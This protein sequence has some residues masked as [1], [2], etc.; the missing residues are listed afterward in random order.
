MRLSVAAF[1]TEDEIERLASTVELLAAH[2]PE[3]RPAA[4]DADPDRG[5]GM[6]VDRPPVRPRGPPSPALE[7]RWRQ[8]RN[9][10]RPVVR[11]VMASLVIA[12][13]LAV[14][15]LVYDLALERGRDPA[16]R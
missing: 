13:V 10:P 9:A 6:T 1:T 11:A 4:A 15:Y 12:V 16:G 7:V 8:F 5:R 14:A 3:T 2:T